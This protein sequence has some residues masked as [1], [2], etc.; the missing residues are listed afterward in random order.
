MLRQASL[1]GLQSQVWWDPGLCKGWVSRDDTRHGFLPGS[2]ASELECEIAKQ[3]QG[4]KP[5]PFPRTGLWALVLTAP[6][7]GAGPRTQS[8]WGTGADE[9][10]S[11]SPAL[12]THTAG[13]VATN[14]T[15]PQATRP[16]KGHFI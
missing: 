2:D 4:C 10:P 3:K 7:W 6:V 15:L 11:P 5:H 9:D 1:Q 14:P 8:S 12:R 16:R 13:L